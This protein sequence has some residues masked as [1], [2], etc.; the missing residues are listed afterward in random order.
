MHRY[1]FEVLVENNKSHKT[2]HARLGNNYS[3]SVGIRSEKTKPKE[4]FG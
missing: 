4:D 3:A 2:T 1:D